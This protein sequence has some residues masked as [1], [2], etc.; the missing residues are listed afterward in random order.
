MFLA[1]FKDKEFQDKII[2]F[3]EVLILLGSFFKEEY[4]SNKGILILS[5][6]TLLIINERRCE[7]LVR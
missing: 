7:C 5:C 6:P 1:E 3:Y 4:I 2:F